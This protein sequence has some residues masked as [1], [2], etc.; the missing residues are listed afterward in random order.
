M[1][2]RVRY[3]SVRRV[4]Y[5][6]RSLMGDAPSAVEAMV[7]RSNVRNAASDIT[8][9]LW[10]DGACFAQV[11]EGEKDVVE[12]LFERIKMDVSHD[13]IEIVLD[14]EVSHR[15]FGRWGMAQPDDSPLSTYNSAFL[16]GLAA[17]DKSRSCQRLADVVI[18]SAG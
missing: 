6:S 3:A 17:T 13:D 1:M 15:L 9:M 8:G 5:T 18:A 16:I 2:L 10:S 11:L 4:I 7:E 14:R 12:A